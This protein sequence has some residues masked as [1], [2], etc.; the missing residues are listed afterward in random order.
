MSLIQ[1]T[2]FQTPELF[3]P[4]TTQDATR[5]TVQS[6]IDKYQPKFLSCV[7]GDNM[8]KLFADALAVNEV[9]LTFNGVS[10]ATISNYYASYYSVFGNTPRITVNQLLPSGTRRR[11]N[12]VYVAPTVVNGLT[13]SID[14]DFGVAGNYQV[15]LSKNLSGESELSFSATDTLVINDWQS[16]YAA[17]YGN[18][19]RIDVYEVNGTTRTLRNDVGIEVLGEPIDH[20]EIDLGVGVQLEVVVYGVPAIVTDRWIDLSQNEVLKQALRCYVY[21]YYSRYNTTFTTSMGEKKGQ[22]QNSTDASGVWKQTRAWNEM[23]QLCWAL[24]NT[25]DRSIYPEYQTITQWPYFRGYCLPE[26]YVPINALNI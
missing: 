2:D 11:R 8:A 3:I 18:N 25:V 21:F 23:V 7:F 20:I 5:E 6:F 14:L 1:P 12:D 15:I 9:A 22:S 16:L 13:I 24:N 10:S 19:P 4:N 17:Q 26:V